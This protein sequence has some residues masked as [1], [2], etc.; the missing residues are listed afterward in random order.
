MQLHFWYNIA[1]LCLLVP[2]LSIAS[3]EN[4]DKT[5]ISSHL[6]RRE[7]KK[8]LFVS[9]GWAAGGMPFSVL[10]VPPYSSKTPQTTNMA[11][12]MKLIAKEEIQI[13]KTQK[14]KPLTKPRSVI[15]QLFVSYGWGPLGRR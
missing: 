4:T 14:T 5:S 6:V 12:K 2:M 11:P 1:A 8:D 10:Y 9:R 7:N 13:K 15:P 3:T